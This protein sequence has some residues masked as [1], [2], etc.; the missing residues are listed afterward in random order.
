MEDTRTERLVARVDPT[1]YARAVAVAKARYE[2][3]VSMLVRL[4]VKAFVEQ[5]ERDEEAAA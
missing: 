3:S 2:G 1:L 5:A 4:A